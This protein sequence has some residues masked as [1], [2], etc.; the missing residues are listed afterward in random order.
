MNK[1]W[2]NKLKKVKTL[3]CKKECFQEGIVKLIELRNILFSEWI[4]LMNSQDKS[5]FSLQ[6]FMN[7]DGYDSKSIAYCIYH[8][9]RIE[10]IV[11]NSLILDKKQIFFEKNYN[12]KMK[13]PIITTGNEI[14]KDKIQVFSKTIDINYLCEYAQDV[15]QSSNRMFSTLNFELSKRRF[16]CNDITRLQETNCVDLEYFCLIEYWCN[17]NI[18]ELLEMPFSRHWIMHL[19]ASLRIKKQIV[20]DLTIN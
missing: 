17:K 20:K 4:K 8:V 18:R 19:E 5:I 16:T 6:P 11:L 13:S 7:R 14:S 9:F 12:K 3:L 15:F 2:S 10:D 1:E